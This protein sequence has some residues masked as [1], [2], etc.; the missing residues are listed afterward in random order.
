MKNVVFW[1]IK[2]QFVPQRKYISLRYG[3]QPVNATLRFE[4]FTVV[5]MK[6]ADFCDAP[7]K[8]RFLQEPY[9]VTSRKTEFYTEYTDHYLGWHTKCWNAMPCNLVARSPENRNLNTRRRDNLKNHKRGKIN[10]GKTR[11]NSPCA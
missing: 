4:V 6:N 10:H 5:T 9:G 1:D 7:P 3:G 8:R 11:Q 2:I